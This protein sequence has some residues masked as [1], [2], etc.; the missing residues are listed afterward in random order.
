MNPYDILES[1]QTLIRKKRYFL[2]GDKQFLCDHGGLY[3]MIER[4]GKYIP[5]N[6]Y[7]QMNEILIKNCEYKTFLGLDSSEDIPNFINH[8]VSESNMKCNSY[9]TELWNGV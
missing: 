3:P 4:K 6:L 1:E 2:I 8:E 5:G 7:N 9:T